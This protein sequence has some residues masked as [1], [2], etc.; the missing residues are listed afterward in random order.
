[1]EQRDLARGGRGGADRLEL[2]LVDAGREAVHHRDALAASRP[3][4][5]ADSG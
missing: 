5:V 2:V 1:M 4:Q 3:D